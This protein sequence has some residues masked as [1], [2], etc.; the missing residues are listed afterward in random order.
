MDAMGPSNTRTGRERDG[1]GDAMGNIT[2]RVAP[3]AAAIAQLLSKVML[4]MMKVDCWS[5]AWWPRA[6]AAS[7]VAV[8]KSAARAYDRARREDGAHGARAP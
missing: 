7:A 8:R 5:I 4:P 6:A 3:A 1:A 2:A